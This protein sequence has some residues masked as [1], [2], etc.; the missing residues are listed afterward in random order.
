M[1]CS[2]HRGGEVT[3]P[4]LATQ[5]TTITDVL[6]STQFPKHSRDAT[7]KQSY[8]ELWRIWLAGVRLRC[9]KGTSCKVKCE[10]KDVLN[11]IRLAWF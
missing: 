10:K 7:S 2:F 1:K 4:L 5:L 11:Q 6:D 8:V 9:R 3:I